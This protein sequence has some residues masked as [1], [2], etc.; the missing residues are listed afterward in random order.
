MMY[1]GAIS[2]VTMKQDI[3]IKKSSA[4]SEFADKVLAFI[5]EYLE[6]TPD[7]SDLLKHG[8]DQKTPIHKYIYLDFDK[9]NQSQL[10]PYYYRLCKEVA[11]DLTIRFNIKSWAVQRFPSLRVQYPSNISVFEEH[12]DSDYNHPRGEINHFLAITDCND[13]SSL[14]VEETLGW[15]DFKPLNLSKGEYAT[16][17]TSVFEHG[18][19]LNNSGCT[20]ISCDFRFIP[21]HVITSSSASKT[22][23]SAG[24]LFTTEDYYIKVSEI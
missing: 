24:K 16:L 10:L 6:N 12:I 1:C 18:D 11:Q 20:R 21:T 7:S 22:S 9:L 5:S 4:S 13:T 2:T 19:R 3:L 14:W 8:T 17:N 23:I 15:R